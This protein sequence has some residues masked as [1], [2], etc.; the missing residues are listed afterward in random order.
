MSGTVRASS[1]G[2]ESEVPVAQALAASLYDMPEIN[3]GPGV[4]EEK[5]A[6]E[7]RLT[8]KLKMLNPGRENEIE[9]FFNSRWSILR[10]GCIQGV[11]QEI[12]HRLVMEFNSVELNDLR[13]FSQSESGS[14]FFS[15]LREAV[16]SSD[17]VPTTFADSQNA[18][19]FLNGPTGQHFST[20]HEKLMS[21][22]NHWVRTACEAGQVD[23]AIKLEN[24]LKSL[25]LIGIS[26][27]PEALTSG[28]AG[29]SEIDDPRYKVAALLKGNQEYKRAAEILNDLSKEGNISAKILLASLYYDGSGVVKNYDTAFKLFSEAANANDSEGEYNVAVMYIKGQGTSQD[30]QAAFDWLY[31]SAK[32]GYPPAE[33]V[34][35]DQYM[36]GQGVQQDS[37]QALLWYQRAAHDG[38]APAQNKLGWLYQEGILVEKSFANAALWHDKAAQQGNASGEFNLGR[39]YENGLG[40]P[41]DYTRSVELYRRAAEKGLPAAQFGMGVAY[42]FGKGVPQDKAAAIDW[43]SKAANQGYAEAQFSLGASYAG[44]LGVPKNMNEAIKWYLRAA[45]QGHGGAQ[46]NLGFAYGLGTG[47][48]VS[49]VEAY[50]WFTLSASRPETTQPDAAIKNRDYAASQM[51]AAQLDEA[52]KLVAEWQLHVDARK[53]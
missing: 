16:Y 7:M 29:F 8:G 45:N 1:Q 20:F 18:F 53:H 38:Y 44:G 24:G 35:A 47:A 42:A 39:L 43:Y 11:R 15:A 31:K 36:S 46:F 52:K 9:E 10:T 6:T 12:A 2:T 23:S 25:N 50:K 49:L 33:L 5:L 32:S 51:T 34:I 37:Y 13:K 26:R 27:N 41:K 40:V 4:A 14:K 21:N 17:E 28:P 3:N 48:P 30:F 22:E 19:Q